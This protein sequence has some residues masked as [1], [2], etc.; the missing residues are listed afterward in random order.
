[1]K[2]RKWGQ[3]DG[4]VGEGTTLA[5]Q[6]K[7]WLKFSLVAKFSPQNPYEKLNVMAHVCN[8][9]TRMVGEMGDR[10]RI[11][12]KVSNSAMEQKQEVEETAGKDPDLGSVLSGR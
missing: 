2:N 11:G 5:T 3:K 8:H 6:L 1:M 9:G 12:Q 10:H 7:W 4:A